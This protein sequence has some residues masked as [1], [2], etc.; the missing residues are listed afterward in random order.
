MSTVATSVLP[1]CSRLQYSKSCDTR[2]QSTVT[3]W[4]IVFYVAFSS[5]FAS[6]AFSSPLLPFLLRQALKHT[7]EKASGLHH[8]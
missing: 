8:L 3:V 4:L 7:M 5:L 1:F 6:C 2:P